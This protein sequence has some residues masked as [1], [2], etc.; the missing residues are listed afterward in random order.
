MPMHV[1]YIEISFTKI[2]RGNKDLIIHFIIFLNKNKYNLQVIF[3]L[4][5]L[6]RY[7]FSS[8]SVE[9]ISFVIICKVF[10]VNV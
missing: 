9:K 3:F 1:A 10:L 6:I 4:K 2:M 7:S 8:T 5:F